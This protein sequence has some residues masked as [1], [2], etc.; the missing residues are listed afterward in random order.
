MQKKVGAKRRESYSSDECVVIVS[1]NLN[2][3]RNA[4]GI[5]KSHEF[6]EMF[7]QLYRQHSHKSWPERS[8]DSLISKW[9]EISRSVQKFKGCW[10]RA[11]TSLQGRSGNKFNDSD[12]M[13]ESMSS[14]ETEHNRPFPFQACWH[15]MKTHAKW[16]GLDT[17][18]YSEAPIRMKLRNFA[19]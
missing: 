17:T 9:D 13:N 15:I 16:N 11:K 19:K 1:A 2:A 7:M 18:S 3:R 6:R 14:F 4:H 10:C 8:V 12:I 5:I